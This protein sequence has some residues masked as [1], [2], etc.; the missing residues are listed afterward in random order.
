MGTCNCRGTAH[1][2]G[3]VSALIL[4]VV[5]NIHA[6]MEAQQ[7]RSDARMNFFVSSVG[8]GAGGNLG[9]V[10]GA[11]ALCTRLAAAAGSHRTQ[12]RA[13][14]SSPARPG[15]MRVN[16]R[17]R[18]GHGPW[19]NFRGV[20]IASTLEELHSPRNR[21]AAGTALTEIGGRVDK[22]HDILTGSGPDGTLAAIASDTTC[23]GWTS[24][25][26]GTAMVGHADRI[27]GPTA[28]NAAH[29]TQGCS[30]RALEEGDG[31]GAIYCFALD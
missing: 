9:G 15:T 25:A 23:H 27:G 30:A 19:F 10:R 13:Y 18:I 28:W 12:W 20:E 16:A 11:D 5:L 6:T 29:L 14:L 21:I 4:G 22:R 26:A 2:A 8:T 24:A 1:D 3:T 7:G 31:V 17:D